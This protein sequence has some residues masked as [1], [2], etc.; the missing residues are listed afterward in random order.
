MSTNKDTF[1][2]IKENN[3]ADRQRLRTLTYVIGANFVILLCIVFNWNW[4]EG[5]VKVALIVS[6]CYLLFVC[7]L[8]MVL[9]KQYNGL[10]YEFDTRNECWKDY[11][12]SPYFVY[13][14]PSPPP[15]N[16]KDT[17]VIRINSTDYAPIHNG[18]YVLLSDGY[19]MND[20]YLKANNKNGSIL[21]LTDLNNKDIY[22]SVESNEYGYRL[23]FLKEKLQEDNL[24][25]IAVYNKYGDIRW[26]K[27]DKKTC[28]SK[29][30]KVLYEIKRWSERL[31]YIAMVIIPI[32]VV[33]MQP[34]IKL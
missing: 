3:L 25:I 17:I 19:C 13:D 29:W 16:N 7:A 20:R 27:S 4:W 1:Y 22:Y 24:T 8:H 34:T 18:D 21:E 12:E 32:V 14:Y 33:L 26:M 30:R 31:L 15:T 5:C 10:F 9:E 23:K 2:D 11:Y 6:I 28:P